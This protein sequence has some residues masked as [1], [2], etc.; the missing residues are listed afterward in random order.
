MVTVVQLAIG[1]G[2]TF[3]GL[4]FDLSGYRATFE[5]SAAVL[6]LAA[7]FAYLAGRA[8]VRKKAVNALVAAGGLL[9]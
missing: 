7:V 6:V 2:A 5:L 9:D 8:A 3:G 4:A 1:L